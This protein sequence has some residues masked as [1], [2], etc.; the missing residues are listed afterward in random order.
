MESMERQIVYD[1]STEWTKQGNPPT[2]ANLK[3]ALVIVLGHPDDKGVFH[4][5]PDKFAAAQ[6]ICVL[7]L[8]TFGPARRRGCF[9]PSPPAHP[10]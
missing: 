1:S 10:A 3:K 4:A 5:N 2:R 7:G 8:H 6:I 9:K